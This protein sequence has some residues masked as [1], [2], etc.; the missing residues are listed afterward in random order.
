[1]SAMLSNPKEKWLKAGDVAKKLGIASNR[2]YEL[3]PHACVCAVTKPFSYDPEVVE[4]FTQYLSLSEM[5]EWCRQELFDDNAL[6]RK[7]KNLVVRGQIKSIQLRG[8]HSTRYLPSSSQKMVENIFRH[9]RDMERDDISAGLAST[10]AAAR[11]IGVDRETIN[12]L[13]N[14]YG[15]EFSLTEETKIPDSLSVEIGGRYGYEP[16]VPFV[17]WVGLVTDAHRFLTTPVIHYLKKYFS[18]MERR[19]RSS[20]ARNLVDFIRVDEEQHRHCIY[21]QNR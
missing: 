12:Y 3:L 17:K 11:T 5:L 16:R 15:V 19:G 6:V 10:G 4:K 14:Q 9:M 18:K 7:A 1:M 2:V 8:Y 13:L 21:F 20:W